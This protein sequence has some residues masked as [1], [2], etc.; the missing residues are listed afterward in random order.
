MKVIVE[1][2]ETPE[3]LAMIREFGSN[4]VQGYLLGRPT[5]DPA[6]HLRPFPPTIVNIEAHREEE[7][8]ANGKIK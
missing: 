1:G 7:L 4:E 6:S 5:P 2:V 8:V 3:E